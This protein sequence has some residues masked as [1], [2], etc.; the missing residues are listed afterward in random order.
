MPKPA[1]FPCVHS[2]TQ[3]CLPSRSLLTTPGLALRPMM[4]RSLRWD[5][6]RLKSLPLSACSLSGLL[7]GRPA[8]SAIA[9]AHSSNILES[10]L[11]APLAKLTRGLPLASTTMCCASIHRVEARF[12]A[13]R[14][15]GTEEPS[16]LAC[17]NRSDRQHASGTAWPGAIGTRHQRHSIPLDTPAR[18]DL[19]VSKRLGK[20]FSWDACLQHEHNAVEAA[21]SLNAS[22]YAPLKAR[23][24]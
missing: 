12:L 24:L 17:S 3:R 8:N 10:C 23:R 16:M 21:S 14:G 1:N 15:L 2:T 11:F 9:L 6:H 19:T 22:L 5:L 18:D 7:R 13:P 4:P 20:V